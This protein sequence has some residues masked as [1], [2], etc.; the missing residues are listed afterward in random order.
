MWLK[1]PKQTNGRLDRTK[2]GHSSRRMFFASL[3]PS[4]NILLR[5][6]FSKAS[7]PANEAFWTISFM[8]STEQSSETWDIIVACT[9]WGKQIDI[10]IRQNFHLLPTIMSTMPAWSYNWSQHQSG[11]IPSD[12]EGSSC[13]VEP[14]PHERRMR[15][16]LPLSTDHSVN[17]TKSR[18]IQKKFHPL[19]PCTWKSYSSASA[20][21]LHVFFRQKIFHSPKVSV[22]LSWCVFCS[23]FVFFMERMVEAKFPS[24]GLKFLF[25]GKPPRYFLLS[26]TACSVLS[27][28]QRLHSLKLFRM[29]RNKSEKSREMVMLSSTIRPGSIQPPS[30]EQL[31]WRS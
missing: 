14:K 4:W 3:Y 10:L 6:F 11:K 19:I 5:K 23:K 28:V 25:P 30:D 17:L 1:L 20:S 2:I 15:V 9:V 8:H 7:E 12:Y 29:T 22:E 13:A 31:Q 27:W 24:H 21:F 26:N 16:K 18:T